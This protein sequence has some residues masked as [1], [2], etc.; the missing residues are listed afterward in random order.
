MR[1]LTLAVLASIATGCGGAGVHVR[2]R[3]AQAL[4]DVVLTTKGATV[5]IEAIAAS[6]EATTSICPRG[7]AG[8]FELSFQSNGHAYHSEQVGYFECDF[9]YRIDVDVSPT[10]DVTSRVSLR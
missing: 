4:R 1:V 8:R 9:L 6:G 10:F 7:E 5:R 2:N 3:S